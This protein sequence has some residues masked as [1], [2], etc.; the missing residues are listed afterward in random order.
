MLIT[1]SLMFLAACSGR[2]NI[3]DLA[4]EYGVSHV[5]SE[6]FEEASKILDV[7]YLL[8]QIESNRVHSVKH[9][10]GATIKIDNLN[11]NVKVYI[12]PLKNTIG[13]KQRLFHL[14]YIQPGKYDLFTSIGTKKRTIVIESYKRY[15]YFDIASATESHADKGLGRIKITLQP[16]DAKI[17]IY[18]TPHKYRDGLRLPGGQYRVKVSK[19]GFETQTK[20]LKVQKNRLTEESFTLSPTQSVARKSAE[21][22]STNQIATITQASEVLTSQHNNESKVEQESQLG[23]WGEL[24]ITPELAGVYYQLTNEK[25]RQ[26]T[27]KKGAAFDAGEYKVNA[28][29]SNT[30]KIL[31]SK[32]VKIKVYDIARIHF[33]LEQV[34]AS[35][36]QQ[37]S[38]EVTRLSTQRDRA[39]L[40]LSS[41]SDESFRFTKR[42]RRKSEL[43][44]F[45][46]PQGQYEVEL[47]AGGVLYQ[48]GELNFENGA[49]NEFKFELK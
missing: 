13:S 48:L 33:E 47:T 49:D 10:K 21:S 25:G 8:S 3:K 9:G 14:N 12:Q 29:Q 24:A 35:V 15:D 17:V 37:V 42:F 31:Q 38:I 20:I 41:Q 5:I 6:F 40:T 16:V 11:S 1:F 19:A 32:T 27:Y 46:V 2:S 30:S 26:I 39:V 28:I 22:N 18:G 4:K 23:A 36:N 45:E 44:E 34:I 7:S 43:F